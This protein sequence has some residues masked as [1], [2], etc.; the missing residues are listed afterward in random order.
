MSK[1]ELYRQVAALHVA[2]IDQGF[3]SLLGV[4]FVSLMYQAIDEGEESVLLVIER[5]DRVIGFVAG[6]S[7]MRP[8]YRRMLRH[9][10]R[11]ML[12]LLPSL[13]SL[14]RVRRMLEILRYSHRNDRSVHLP[15][16]ELLSIAVDPAY[17]GQQH[18]ETLYRK[19]TEIF[20]RQGIDEFK[21]I[22]GTALAPAHRFYRRMGALPI[23]EIEVHQ[24]E[25][26]TI[27]SQR[28]SMT[29]DAAE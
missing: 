25:A 29:I 9:A 20:S 27:Y 6:G 11:V 23:A 18:A 21:I 2:N 7:G 13:F 12:A 22:V 4:R 28:L 24:N 16:A 17:R 10:P 14:R 1:R 3:L 15:R 8:I 5:D 19:L 26:S